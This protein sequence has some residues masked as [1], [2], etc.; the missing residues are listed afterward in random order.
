MPAPSAEGLENSY[1]VPFVIRKGVEVR[2]LGDARPTLYDTMVNR[3]LDGDGTLEGRTDSIRNDDIYAFQFVDGLLH[4][5]LTV[6]PHPHVLSA[7]C[8]IPHDIRH[9]WKHIS[10]TPWMTAT[11][12]PCSRCNFS[13]SSSARLLLAL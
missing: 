11:R 13:A 12:A 4:H 10:R 6:C 7:K 2:K 8:Q 3:R 5:P 9:C 1:L